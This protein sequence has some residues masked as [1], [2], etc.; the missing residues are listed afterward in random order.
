MKVM[1]LRILLIIAFF[2]IWQYLSSFYPPYLFPSVWTTFVTLA[3]LLSNPIILRHVLATFS[4]VTVALFLSCII[5]S[6][7]GVLTRYVRVIDILV[8][9]ILIPLLQSVPSICWAILATLWFGISDIS[10]VFI[11][12]VI[13]TPFFAINMSEGIKNID[14]EILE[15]A[16]V[17]TRKR[18]RIFM[19]VVLPMLFSYFFSGLR[20]SFGV[21]WKVSAIAELIGGGSGIGY[22]IEL[23]R[24]RIQTEQIFAWTA[25]FVIVVGI[26]EFCFFKPLENRLMKWRK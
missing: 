13:V 22:L 17:Y 7:M 9:T 25:L 8:E 15:V 3:N 16:R 26:A 18:F 11:I 12:S 19:V 6:F 20:T 2:A 4:R 24:E 5:G 23:A 14:E 1:T 21:A 10:A